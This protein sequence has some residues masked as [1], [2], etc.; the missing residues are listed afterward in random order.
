M[1][2]YVAFLRGVNLGPVRRVPMAVLAAVGRGLGY[3]DVWTWAGSGNLVLTT[4]REAEDVERE[5]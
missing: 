4:A 2:T 1:T 3:D 5:V